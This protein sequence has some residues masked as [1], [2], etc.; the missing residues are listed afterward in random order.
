MIGFG[1]GFEAPVCTLEADADADAGVW[2]AA[3]DRELFDDPDAPPAAA[4]A[5]TRACCAA[6][7][8]AVVA[9]VAAP[10]AGLG[11]G[12]G[13]GAGGGPV[14]LAALEALAAA[15]AEGAL[16][17]DG[18]KG[19][20][21]GTCA[22]RLLRFVATGAPSSA[23][24]RYTDGSG[25][26]REFSGRL[27]ESWNRRLRPR[28]QPHDSEFE[29]ISATRTRDTGCS[30]ARRCNMNIHV[31]AIVNQ[32]FSQWSPYSYNKQTNK[33]RYFLHSFRLSRP[34]TKHY[35]DSSSYFYE[36]QRAQAIQ[37]AYHTRVC[38]TSD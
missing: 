26:E 36:Y 2:E 12:A 1:F 4:A 23:Q 34:N 10:A 11:A 37:T 28:S 25:Y 14:A 30:E 31:K 32:L 19:G 9:A 35:T 21:R 27:R 3:V 22:V 8:C 24:P 20:E 5:C 16:A 15:A 18:R 6:A 33:Q 13:A 38:C 17:G 7:V 29:P